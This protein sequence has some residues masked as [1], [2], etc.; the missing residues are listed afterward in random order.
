MKN[1]KPQEHDEQDEHKITMNKNN[2]KRIMIKRNI[3]TQHND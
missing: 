3:R 2:N 1:F